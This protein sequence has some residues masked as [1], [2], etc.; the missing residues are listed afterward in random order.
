M[1]TCSFRV[2]F[3]LVI[4]IAL[5]GLLNARVASAE[6]YPSKPIRLIV[7]FGAGGSVDSVGRL[8]GHHLSEVLGQSVVVEARPGAGSTIGTYVV[9]NAPR[10]G[11]MLLM[12]GSSSTS[13]VSVYKALPYN[14]TRDFVPIGSVGY[15][16]FVAVLSPSVPAKSL[17][18]FIELAK[19]KP[20]Y[21]NYASSG[22]G[23][24]S[25]LAVELFKSMADVDVVHIPFN[26]A[27]AAVNGTLQSSAQLMFVNLV[28]VQSFIRSGQLTAIGVADSKRSAFLPAVPTMAEAGLPGYEFNE[29]WGLMAP[30]GVPR[31]V[32]DK[33]SAAL[34]EV[35]LRPAVKDAL[36]TMGAVPLS[37][38]AEQFGQRIQRDIEKYAKIVRDAKITVN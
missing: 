36:A 35:V 37:E 26:G 15:T 9:A 12:A 22:N 6:G 31:E 18:E 13:A 38:G 5:P 14:F 28:S 23:V 20:G 4:A 10:D 29:W 30:A 3:L 17:S 2:A 16:P 8:I 32:T 11:Y 25:H 1:K 34:A 21:Y 27:P 33:L 24:G 19:G 7:P